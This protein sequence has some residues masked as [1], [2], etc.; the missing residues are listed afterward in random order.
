MYVPVGPHTGTRGRYPKREKT[1]QGTYIYV[2]IYR[3]YKAELGQNIHT[4]LNDVKFA[5]MFFNILFASLL[6]ISQSLADQTNRFKTLEQ[7]NMRWASCTKFAREQSQILKTC[8]GHFGL[9][10]PKTLHMLLAF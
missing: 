3:Y 10:F 4:P 5:R 2:Y 9:L 7:A 8:S 1:I 6:C